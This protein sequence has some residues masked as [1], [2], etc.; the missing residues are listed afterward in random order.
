M[1]KC[2]WLTDFRYCSAL[3][4]FSAKI[5]QVNPNFK[6]NVNVKIREQREAGNKISPM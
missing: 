2:S 3:C 4:Y 5:T 6:C 1:A